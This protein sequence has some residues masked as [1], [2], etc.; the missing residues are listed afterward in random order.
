MKTFTDNSGK[1][2]TMSVTVDAIKRVRAT[3]AVDLL[4]A[5]SGE[6]I[7]KIATDPILLC[8][9]IYVVC[10]PEA[11][12]AGITD[13]QFGRAMAGDAIDR[14]TT[15]FLEELVDFFPANRRKVLQEAIAKYHVLEEKLMEYA[16]KA[17]ND[18]RMEEEM[19][20]QL[21]QKISDYKLRT[22]TG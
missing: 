18:P 12:A 6:L 1:V 11:D 13:E 2:W 21:K 22:S 9:I 15:S 16:R 20:A 7:K 14:A 19:Y 4:D 3:L 17:I 8:D 5:I 10:K